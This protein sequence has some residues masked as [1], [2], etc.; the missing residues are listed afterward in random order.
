[1]GGLRCWLLAISGGVKGEHGGVPGTPF[2]PFETLRRGNFTTKIEDFSASSATHCW[3]ARRSNC[4]PN[5]RN[6]GKTRTGRWKHD[7][8]FVKLLCAHATGRHLNSYHHHRRVFFSSP[9]CNQ[10]V[11]KSQKRLRQSGLCFI[12]S[13]IR[14]AP[15]HRF[16]TKRK[17]HIDRA[18]HPTYTINSSQAMCP[19]NT[20]LKF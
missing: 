16:V 5:D 8:T 19:P 2:N 11:I 10:D 4:C 14:P 7:P 13:K 6:T 12:F 17:L 18:K 20:R 9:H 1:M 3:L 15:K